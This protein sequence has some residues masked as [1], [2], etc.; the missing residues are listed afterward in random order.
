MALKPVNAVVVGA[1][2]GGGVVAKELACAGFTVVLLERGKWYS[3]YD[4]RKDDLRNQRTT[5]LGCAFGPDDERYRRVVVSADGTERIVL[6]SDGEYNNN[7]A[8]VGGGTFSAMARWRGA[9]WKTISA[10]ARCT[11]RFPAARST[12][13]PSPT[14][15]WSLTT[16]RLSGKSAFPATIPP[17]SLKRREKSRCPCRRCRPAWSTPRW[18]GPP[19]V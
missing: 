3:A 7:A 13:G 4:C 6:P 5:D 16:K 12:T 15:T 10:C 18:S 11:A 8:C 14:T 19:S 2:A 17:T 1:G 9:S